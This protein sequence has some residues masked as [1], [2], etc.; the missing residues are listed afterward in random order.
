MIYANFVQ[1]WRLSWITKAYA[2][3][4]YSEYYILQQALIIDMVSSHN[5]GD[6]GYRYISITNINII[7]T[8]PTPRVSIL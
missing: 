5:A 7:I 4:L 3:I 6:Y 1:A 8:L 2:Y